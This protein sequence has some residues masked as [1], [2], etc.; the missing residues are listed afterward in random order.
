MSKCGIYKITNLI[1]NK[2]YIGQSVDIE[3]R[4]RQHKNNYDNKNEPSYDYHLYRSIR[5]YGI[6]NFK[7]EIIEECDY[8]KLN[9]RETYWIDY[10][11]S[12]NNGYNET[13]GGGGKL[14]VDREEFKKYFIENNPSV[15]EIA[16]Y[17]DIDRSVAGKIM[18][19]LGL[20]AKYYTNKNLENVICEEYQSDNNISILYLAKKYNR[21]P[22]TISRILKRNNIRVRCYGECKSQRILVYD[23]KT[24]EFLMDTYVNEFCNYL[25]ENNIV[26][27]PKQNTIKNAVK[28][29]ANTTYKLFHIEPYHKKAK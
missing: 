2:C 18:K 19:E 24:K 27:N 7:F 4:F 28:R 3:K 6:E 25:K 14:Q 17:F 11:D 29:N 16:E 20:K 8:E 1:N 10:Y 13:L 23:A 12:Y 9:E 21:D 22:E 26:E 5:K 15:K